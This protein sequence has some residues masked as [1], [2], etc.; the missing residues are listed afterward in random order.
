MVYSIT[1][2]AFLQVKLREI[3]SEQKHY[4]CK[5]GHDHGIAQ[6]KEN[7][8]CRLCGAPIEIVTRPRLRFPYESELIPPEHRGR[9]FMPYDSGMRRGIAFFVGNEP[10]ERDQL[11]SEITG[12]EYETGFTSIAA[13]DVDRCIQAFQRNYGDLIELIRP[14]VESLEVVFGVLRYAH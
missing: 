10:I 3:Y 11:M 9:L 5:N 13:A 7:L 6:D 8:F 2:G 14:Q 4:V 1:V 12:G